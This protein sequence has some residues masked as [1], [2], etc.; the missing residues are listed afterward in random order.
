VQSVSLVLFLTKA[1]SEAVAYTAGGQKRVITRWRCQK[2]V[3]RT[4]S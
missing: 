3:K 2:V 4:A 1:F